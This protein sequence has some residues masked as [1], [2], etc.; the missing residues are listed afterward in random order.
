[1]KNLIK[2]SSFL[3]AIAAI[4]VAASCTRDSAEDDVNLNAQY[5][6]AL[7]TIQL[8][9]VNSPAPFDFTVNQNG[10]VIVDHDITLTSGNTYILNNYFRVQSGVTIT[11]EPGAI[12]RG[13]GSGVG[14][15]SVAGT[16]VI[17][18]GGRIEAEGTANAPIVFTSNQA[19]PTPGDWGGVV[20]LGRAAVNIADPGIPGTSNG[21]GAIE[22]LPTPNNTGLYGQNPPVN[23]DNSGTMRYVR[24]EY[25]GDVI[26]LNNELNGLTLGGVGSGT[27][28]E[29]IQVSY[30]LDDGF[31]FFGGTVNASYLVANRNGDDDFDTDQGY[32]GNLQF[33]VSIREQNGNWLASAPLN[34]SET[35]GDDDDD[36]LPTPNNFTSANFSNFT[37]VGPYQNDCSGTV[38]PNYSSG[39]YF[40]DNSDQNIHNSVILG[41]E[42][43]IRI[44]D[45]GAANF[46]TSATLADN[47]IDVRNT[48]IVIPAPGQGDRLG[49]LD[50]ATGSNFNNTFLTPALNN[51]IVTAFSCTISG[52]TMGDLIGLRDGA[53]NIGNQPDLRP[54]AGSDLLNSASFS[55]LPG[56]FQQVT[57]RGAF[58]PSSTW[59]N[60]WTNWTF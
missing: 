40:R 11:I 7:A 60:G 38:N 34:G 44:N 59:M 39:I 41:F 57:Y 51:D 37:F 24:I 5:A 36:Y 21:V 52:F 14:C 45:A 12:I 23:N 53:W 49:T 48:T 8:G 55:G 6:T 46:N 16:L 43:G 29:Y 9:C 58:G 56:Y 19:N 10:D 28:L 42:S 1:M 20:I 27:T 50:D 26:G 3:L 18:R 54:E 31:E 13:N 47:L 15:S 17:E 22:G 30:G 25:A 33:G 2:S 32:S 35:N 4:L